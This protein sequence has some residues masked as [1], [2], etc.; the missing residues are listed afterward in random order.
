MMRLVIV[1]LDGAPPFQWHQQSFIKFTFKRKKTI[2]IFRYCF[3]DFVPHINY[4]YK[5]LLP[6][7]NPMY[8]HHNTFRC[9]KRFAFREKVIKV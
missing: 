3:V 2:I 4:T 7:T 8:S 9:F 1:P 5:E 6:R